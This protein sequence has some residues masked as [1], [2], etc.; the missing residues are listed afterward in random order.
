MR[1][2]IAS[3][4]SRRGRDR[5]GTLHPAS[6]SLLFYLRRVKMHKSSVLKDITAL[7][8]KRTKRLLKCRRD[9]PSAYMVEQPGLF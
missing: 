9:C 4:G 3:F 1:L 8:R 5:F 2:P 7:G 6:T